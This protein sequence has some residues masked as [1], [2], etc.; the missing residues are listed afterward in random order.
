MA[1]DFLKEYRQHEVTLQHQENADGVY[2]VEQWIKKDMVYDKSL[3]VGLSKELPVGSWIQTYYVDSKDVWDRIESGELQGFSLECMLG[4]E[5]FEKQINIDKDMTID[6]MSFWTKMREVLKE[7]FGKAE[8]K[9][10]D[11]IEPID[12]EDLAAQS[13]FTNV[14]DYVKEV[15]AITEELEEEKAVE[16]APE[17][18]ESVEEPKPTTTP[19]E[20][21]K[22]TE[23]AKN[24]VVE[25]PKKEEVNPHIE[26]LINSL[27]EEIN[28]LKE[29]NTSLNDKVKE[30]SKEPSAKPISVN[31]KPN[32]S[33]TYEAWREVMRGYMG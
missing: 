9:G 12:I 19:T 1:K 27:K 2:L 31:A 15:K 32:A 17:V 7:A 21:E 20:V 23:E 4:L 14:E 11:P 13:G 18:V 5:E 10:G 24:D 22:P 30:M 26:E 6:E 28:A 33:D 25:E 3:A 29:M 8:K 16:A